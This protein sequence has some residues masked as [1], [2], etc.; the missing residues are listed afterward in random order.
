MTLPTACENENVPVRFVAMTLFHCSSV[1]SSVCAA[2]EVTALSIRISI[3]LNSKTVV[4]T[5]A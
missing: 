4:S 5:M 3:R 2:Q 1:I